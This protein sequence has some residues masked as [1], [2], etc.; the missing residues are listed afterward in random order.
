[1]VKDAD[2]ENVPK[3]HKC[4]RPVKWLDFELVK[5]VELFLK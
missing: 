1:M 5:Y 4:Q 3:W 2:I